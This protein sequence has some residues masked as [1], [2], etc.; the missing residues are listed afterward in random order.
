MDFLM[1]GEYAVPVYLLAYGWV[2]YAVLYLG[3]WII[4]S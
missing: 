2:E 4:V 1:Y 3:E